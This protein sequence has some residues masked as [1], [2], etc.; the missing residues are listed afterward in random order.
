M[1][2]VVMWHARMWERGLKKGKA[3]CVKCGGREKNRGNK[4]VDIYFKRRL[5]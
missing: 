4:I 1:N 5:N 2:D 3:K